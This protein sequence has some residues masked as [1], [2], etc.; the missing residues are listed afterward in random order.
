[1]S[2]SAVTT[3]WWYMSIRRWFEERKGL[4]G[5]TPFKPLVYKFQLYCEVLS[6]VKYTVCC[7]TSHNSLKSVLNLGYE[8]SYFSI[9]LFLWLIHNFVKRKKFFSD[10]LNIVLKGVD[11]PPSH[12]SQHRV[13]YFTIWYFCHLNYHI[14]YYVTL[15]IELICLKCKSAQVN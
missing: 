8:S 10:A 5:N 3:Y 11:F 13:H 4:V 6:S 14:L 1:M 2:K 9:W 7:L 15:T 12:S